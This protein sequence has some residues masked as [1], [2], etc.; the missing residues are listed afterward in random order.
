MV[1]IQIWEWTPFV[2]LILSASLSTVPTDIEEAV[3]L[4]T[5]RWW[6]RFKSIMLP[7]MWPGITAALVFQTAFILKQFDMVYS[8]E[9]GGPGSATSVAMIHIERLAFRG[10][11]IGVASAESIIMLVLSILLAQAYIKL[12]YREVG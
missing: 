11:D 7:Y 1:I 4:E 10:F 2:A 5:D 3:I 6:P 9:K 12:F 8:I